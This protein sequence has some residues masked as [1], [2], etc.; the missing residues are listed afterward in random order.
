MARTRKTSLF[1]LGDMEENMRINNIRSIVGTLATDA[2]QIENGTEMDRRE[3][4]ATATA[5]GVSSVGAYGMLGLTAPAHAQ[6]TPQKGGRLRLAILVREQKDPRTYDWGQQAGIARQ[7]NEYLVRYTKD[8]TF[9]GQLLESWSVNDEATEYTLNVRKGVLWNNGDEFNAEDVVFNLTRWCEKEVEGNTMANRVSALIDPETKLAA[10]GAITKV[11][12]FTVVLKLSKPDIA[13]IPA[14]AEYP[15]LIVHR[16]FE[17]MGSDWIANPIGTGPFELVSYDVGNRVVLKR[18]ENG[19]WKGSAHLDEVEFIDYGTKTDAL[20]SAFEAGEIDANHESNGQAIQILDSLG[21]A[22]SEV[23][24]AATAVVRMNANNAPYD[25]Q[26][27]RN[28]VQLS[29]DNNVPLQLGI[30]GLGEVAENFHLSPIHPE[31]VPLAPITR[32]LEK[33]KALMTEAGQMD[34]EFEIISV[35]DDWRRLTADAVAAQ[36]RDAGFNVKRTVM[37]GSTFWK[38]WTKYPFSITN[39]NMR[40]LGV[41]MY[42]IAYQTGAKWNESGFS[43]ARFDELIQQALSTPGVEARKVLIGEAEQI[44]QDS[45]A[46]VQPYWRSLYCHH[47]PNVHGYYKHQTGEVH[48]DDVWMST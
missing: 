24:T 23:G 19:W 27:V 18:R 44:L 25:D 39:W 21:L 34:F 2:K 6:E 45:G 42:A 47:S 7:V 10:E 20:I 3:F 26:R 13:L 31:F 29:V 1:S 8:F 33:A 46:I 15:A 36:M 12:D 22:K 17:K 9:E 40:P 48:L 38:D 30:D 41:Q 28:A 16:D 37:P 35:D 43:D 11:D 14:L 5:L 4:L 32:D